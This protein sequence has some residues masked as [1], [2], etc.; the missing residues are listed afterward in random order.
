MTTVSTSR[1]DTLV[2]LWADE[3]L[4]STAQ[5]DRMHAEIATLEPDAAVPPTRVWSTSLL[6]E[7][8]GYLGGAIVVAGSLL[9]GAFYWDEVGAGARLAV[10]VGAALLL[11][12]AGAVVPTSRGPAGTRLRS[13]LWLASTGATAG[14]LAV[15][16]AD[17]LETPDADS[18]LI[19][20]G[21]AAAYAV[22]LWALAHTF[23]QQV[24]MVVAVAIT[25]AALLDRADFS[26]DTPGLGVW[27]VGVLW[28]VL[29][30][31]DVARPRRPV[32]ALG[33]GLTVIGAM[34]TAGADAGMVLTLVTILAVIALSVAMRDLPLLA[35]GTVAALL[36]TPAAMTRWFPD[37]VAAAF[38]LVVVGAIL[39]VT[40]VWVTRSGRGRP[41]LR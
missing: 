25:A 8:L 41:R 13:L 3:G 20:A 11:L 36:N 10:L 18:F 32:L 40:A 35:V 33:A 23:V 39:L 2:D 4:I 9:I 28:A 24:G 22:V 6:A 12:T 21:G 16:A 30:W 27:A 37:S 5:A 38:A 19:V 26:D 34:T 31:L 14:A 7:A 29:G 15:L 1:I 17:V